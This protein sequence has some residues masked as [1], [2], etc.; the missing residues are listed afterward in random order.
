[1]IKGAALVFLSRNLQKVV[2]LLVSVLI[3]HTLG[4]KGLGAYGLLV[5]TLTYAV[6]F[7]SLGLGPAHVYLRGQGRMSI[8]QL[9]GNA[10]AGALIFGG[11]VVLVFTALRP[12]L[13][14]Q[15]V[16]PLMITLVSLTFPL[17]ILQSHLDFLWQGEDR[18]GI[19]SGMFCF[20]ALLLL[21][22]LVLGLNAPNPYTGMAVALILNSVLTL[23]VTL[24]LLRRKYG[25]RPQFDRGQFSA[26]LRYG[27]R[28]QPGSLAQAVGYRLDYFL[29]NA[30][31]GTAATGQYVL[32]TNLAEALWILPYALSVALLPRV[33]TASVATAQQVTARALRVA[34]AISAAGGLVLFLLAEL[35]LRLVYGPENV[36]AAPALRIL[37]FGTVIFSAQKLLANYFI[38]QGKASWFLRATFIAMV[39]NV[40]LNLWLIPLFGWGIKGAALASTVSY[41]LSTG[42]LAWLFAR[43]SGIPWRDLFVLNRSDIEEMTS[44]LGRLGKR[45]A[46]LRHRGATR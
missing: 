2:A 46:G 27:S 10:L 39:V 45:A 40:A 35:V 17:G 33:S 12:L 3:T 23:A 37:L 5:T 1:M 42:I 22:L 30:F 7:G 18:L 38:G 29:I 14:I 15:G 44:R 13:H 26:A 21:F 36:V 34:L 6:A 19:Y 31:I 24:V 32:A 43:W 28:V 11:A 41:T 9:L 20:R 16:S 8:R 4:A 25:L